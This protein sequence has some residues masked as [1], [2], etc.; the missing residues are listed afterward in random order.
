M[1]NKE[2]RKKQLS[3]SGR[4]RRRVTPRRALP[5]HQFSE[6]KTTEEVEEENLSRSSDTK[7]SRDRVS[8]NLPPPTTS[9]P[10]QQ[11][12]RI[13]VCCSSSSQRGAAATP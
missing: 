2:G 5:L 4:R 12:G 7:T 8:E 13:S 6:V 11:Q 1:W 9:P 3:G 10:L